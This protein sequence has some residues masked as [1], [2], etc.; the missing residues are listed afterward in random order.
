MKAGSDTSCVFEPRFRITC[1]SD[2]AMGPGKARLLRLVKQT[3]SI[4]EAARQMQMSYMRAWTLIRTMNGCFREPVIATSRGGEKRGGATLTP[5]GERLL[6]LYE[7]LQTD[8]M[9]ST[10]KTRLAITALL[11]KRSR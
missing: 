10:A 6:E 8:A 3:G 7:R 4:S 1:G 11:N 5:T 9:A 2:I